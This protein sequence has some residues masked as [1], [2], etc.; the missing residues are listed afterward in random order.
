MVSQ[1]IINS[2]MVVAEV[3]SSSKSKLTKVKSILSIVMSSTLRGGVVKE[4][5]AKLPLG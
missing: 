5:M 4:L 2:G 3:V 1:I